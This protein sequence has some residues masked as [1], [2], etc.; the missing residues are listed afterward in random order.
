MD[1][2]TATQAATEAR[3]GLASNLRQL[4]DEAERLLQSAAR[5]GDEKLDRV[6][7]RVADQVR[8]MRAQLDDL[9]DAAA[10]NARRAVRAADHSVHEHPWRAV[11]IAAAAGA[12]IGVLLA[13]RR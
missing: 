5:S 13:S 3:E 9:Q 6:R 10:Y 1:A 8:E 12:L 7:G 2:S 11:A 4:V